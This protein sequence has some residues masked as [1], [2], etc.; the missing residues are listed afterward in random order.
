[1]SEMERQSFEDS[2]KAMSAE[3]MK[4][5]L[6]YF[7]TDMLWDELRERETRNRNKIQYVKDLV[8]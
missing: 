1:M 7:D 3:E 8:G 6:K 4:M 2:I 5:A